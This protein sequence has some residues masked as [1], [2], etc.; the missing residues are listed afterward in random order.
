MAPVRERK[1]ARVEADTT[2]VPRRAKVNALGFI[3]SLADE[4]WAP[5]PA[6]AHLY[7]LKVKS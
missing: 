4:G 2:Y 7:P 1:M 6:D 3:K 5:F